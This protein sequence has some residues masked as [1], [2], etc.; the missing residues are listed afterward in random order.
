M[1]ATLHVLYTRDA[2][3]TFDMSYFLTEHV[4]M[5][6]R[7]LDG[8]IDFMLVAEGTETY[9]GGAPEV[10]ALVTLVFES[11]ES[12]DRAESVAGP[13]HEDIP[14]FYNKRPRLLVGELVA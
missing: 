12:F 14:N 1:P 11:R 5:T 7:I 13:I 2:D 9:P 3:T 8:F 4:P 10:H 6:R